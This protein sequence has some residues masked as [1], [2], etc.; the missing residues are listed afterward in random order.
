MSNIKIS[1]LPPET[2]LSSIN[3]LAG[4]NNSGTV[5]ISGADLISALTLNTVLTTSNQASTEIQTI[6]DITRFTSNTFSGE[7]IKLS[8][9]GLTRSAGKLYVETADTGIQFKVDSSVTTDTVEFNLGGISRFNINYRGALGVGAN[10]AD[11]GSAGQVLTSNGSS[12]AATWGSAPSLNLQTVVNTGNIIN[13]QNSVG[14]IIINDGNVTRGMRLGEFDN[15]SK[16]GI[17]FKEGVNSTEFSIGVP[18]DKTLNIGYGNASAY[19]LKYSAD[20]ATSTSNLSLGT[21]MTLK[22]NGG[23]ILELADTSLFKTKQT[24]AAGE[25]EGD[26]GQVLTSRGSNLSPEWKDPLP[27]PLFNVIGGANPNSGIQTWDLD[28]GYNASLACNPIGNTLALSNWSEGDT[29]VL[30]LTQGSSAFNFPANSIFAGGAPTLV[31]GQTHVFSL[32]YKSATE[33]IWSYGL[34]FKA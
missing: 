33:L 29:G 10:A 8:S 30:I 19:G 18:V 16:W 22:F 34:D 27:S 13:N 9:N 17:E 2:N 28:D 14:T 26:A 5:K 31:D 32:L 12:N 21:S 1:N 6:S 4:Y 3:G 11:Y 20:N 24:T 25:G 7:N 23:T 15:S